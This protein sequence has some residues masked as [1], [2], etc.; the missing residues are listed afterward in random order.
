MQKALE[1]S[2]PLDAQR[3][4][5][6]ASIRQKSLVKQLADLDASGVH[7]SSDSLAYQQWLTKR[8]NAQ[9]ELTKVDREIDQLKIYLKTHAT[10][11]FDKPKSI[12]EASERISFLIARRTE[13]ESRLRELKSD[14]R[15]RLS[16]ATFGYKE[17]DREVVDLKNE[18]G[19]VNSEYSLLKEIVRQHNIKL[20]NE[21]NNQRY[22]DAKKIVMTAEDILDRATV[23][24][25]EGRHD[26]AL[27]ELYSLLD[28]VQDFKQKHGME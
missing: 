16:Y 1:P 7:S 20:S 9:A 22:F 10:K 23:S 18:L 25:A 12:E 13:I 28:A 5:S 2:S 11:S 8:T 27:P 21:V 6:A 4:L 17:W 3:K 26:E 19:L 14:P 24:I 15:S